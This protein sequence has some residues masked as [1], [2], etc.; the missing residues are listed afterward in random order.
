MVEEVVHHVDGA[1]VAVFGLGTDCKQTKLSPGKGKLIFDYT[2]R[3]PK[4]GVNII[5][6]VVAVPEVLKS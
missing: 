2:S 5:K 1:V 4:I 6:Q 3:T